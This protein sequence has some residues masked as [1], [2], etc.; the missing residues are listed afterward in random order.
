MNNRDTEPQHPMEE[1]FRNYSKACRSEPPN[2]TEQDAEAQAALRREVK[3]GKLGIS[4][5][6]RTVVIAGLNYKT[7]DEATA[8]LDTFGELRLHGFKKEQ[9]LALAEVA[10]YTAARAK[11]LP[12]Q[13]GGEG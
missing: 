8:H 1:A 13:S 9:L 3:A 12:E 4:E 6:Q 5:Y 7:D 11:P 2:P 10:T